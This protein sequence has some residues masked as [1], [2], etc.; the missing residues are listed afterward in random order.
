[1]P[2]RVRRDYNNWEGILGRHKNIGTI[3]FIIIRLRDII[4]VQVTRAMRGAECWTDHRLVRAVL[5]LHI[6]PPHRNQPKTVRISYNV[7]RLKDP[8]YLLKFQQQLDE[9]L[10]DG[11]TPIDGT[12]KWSSFK[13]AVAETAKEVLRAKTKVHENWFDQTDEKIKEALHAKN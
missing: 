1:M 5:S 11:L 4:D 12:G 13:E 6:P 7:A 10:Q 3:D 9:K 2:A 8:T